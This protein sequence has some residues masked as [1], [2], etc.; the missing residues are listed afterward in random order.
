MDDGNCPLVQLLLIE[1]LI[2]DHGDVH[3]VPQVGAGIPSS[4]IRVHVDLPQ[5]FDHF[6]LV[7]CVRFC[8]RGSCSHV[9]RC[10]IVM[11]S[12]CSGY[13]DSRE[14]EGVGD[15]ERRGLV[16]ADQESSRDGRKS[17]R[18]V[19]YDFHDHLSPSY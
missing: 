5:L 9:Q 17:L 18:A 7:I 11:M 12:I 13:F 2:F 1:E 16:H 10:I 3:E 14:G 4:V 15:F 19:L 8:P 6:C